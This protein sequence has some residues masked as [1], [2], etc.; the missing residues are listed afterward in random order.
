[1]T[2]EQ[3]LAL[4]REAARKAYAPYSGFHVGCAIESVDGSVVTGVR[5]TNGQHVRVLDVGEA[6]LGA[7]IAK[8]D[9]SVAVVLGVRGADLEWV[10]VPF[11]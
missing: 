5:V 4:A 3:L 10:F 6:A 11:G 2:D 1:M 7:A 9:R 8:I